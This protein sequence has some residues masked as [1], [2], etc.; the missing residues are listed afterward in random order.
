MNRLIRHLEFPVVILLFLAGSIFLLKMPYIS[1]LQNT[2]FGSL[3]LLAFYG[4]L[5]GRYSV[6]IP[7][8]L[9][10]LVLAAVEVDAVG[11]YFSMYGQ[12]FGP[13]MYDE[14]AHLT[15]QAL[16]TPIIMWLASAVIMRSGYHLPLGL[17]TFF[18]ITVLFS[19]SSFYEIIEFWDELY[20]LGQR[21]GSPYDAPNDLQWGLAGI[22]MG[23]VS[24]YVVMKKYGAIR[25]A[26][27]R[28]SREA[29]VLARSEMPKLSH[30]P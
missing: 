1:L 12:Q 20:F 7:L 23:S 14:F 11:N 21:I 5:Y 3:F 25:F 28:G 24:T 8:V 17:I 19:I 10:L 2:I 18:S 16:T 6:K 13:M 4:Y 15:V 26:V 27:G 22:I 29:G 9:L 30:K